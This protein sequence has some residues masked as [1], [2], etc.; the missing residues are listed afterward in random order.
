VWSFSPPEDELLDD[1]GSASPMSMPDQN[2]TEYQ[3]TH[4][5]PNLQ[6]PSRLS[7]VMPDQDR[8]EDVTMEDAPAV[9]EPVNIAVAGIGALAAGKPREQ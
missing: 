1:Y 6:T 7:E 2:Q 4:S 9:D 8:F 3:E 5:M